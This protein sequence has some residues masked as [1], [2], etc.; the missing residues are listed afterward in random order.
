M[1][2]VPRKDADLSN[3][4]N[5]VGAEWL[6]SPSITLVWKTQGDFATDA[7]NFANYL[8]TRDSAGGGQ[9]ILT[10]T[11]SNVDEQIDDAIPYVKSYINGKY[12]PHD[13]PS[14][15][16]SFG[17]SYT[18][19]TGYELPVDHQKRGIALQM[20]SDAMVAN[21]FTT[22]DYGTTF[23]AGIL[24]TYNKALANVLAG[25]GGVSSQVADVTQLRTSL[26]RVLHS[27]LLVLEGNYPDTFVQVRRQWGFMKEDY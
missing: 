17:I 9:Q 13:G 16:A 10:N 22:Q 7:A 8:Q 18:K 15:F 4:C 12:G 3:V 24:T 20:M 26:R 23:W 21:G 6:A 5:L 19:A 11:L 25:S 2:N 27:L 14:Y 1:R